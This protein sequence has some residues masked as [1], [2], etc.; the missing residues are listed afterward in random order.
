MGSRSMPIVQ[1]CT[2]YHHL[3]KALASTDQILRK[4]AVHLQ[5]YSH[6]IICS[7]K[8]YIQQ[9]L[10]TRFHF[11]FIMTTR[12]LW[13]MLRRQTNTRSTCRPWRVYAS[14]S[15]NAPHI[16]MKQMTKADDTQRE[17]YGKT[18]NCHMTASRSTD[19]IYSYQSKQREVQMAC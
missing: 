7:I 10:P 2:D 3:H 14:W 15:W 1:P 9:A 6:L 17:E 5:R 4:C 8:L 19:H 13:L 16:K 12:M 18:L 11:T